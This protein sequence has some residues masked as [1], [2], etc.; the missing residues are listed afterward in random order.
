MRSS[1]E[2][3][4]AVPFR[5]E[6]LH[7][8]LDRNAHD[9]LP[10]VDPGVSLQLRLLFLLQLFEVGERRTLKLGS[11]ERLGRWRRPGPIAAL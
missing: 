11:R 2:P 3:N 1:R 7:G 5:R 10:L 6:D 4:A 9:A 8:A